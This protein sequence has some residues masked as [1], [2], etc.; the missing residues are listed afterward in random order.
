MYLTIAVTACT[1]GTYG[2]NCSGVC[3]CSDNAT[4]DHITGQCPSTC[5]DGWN[6]IDCSI[7][8]E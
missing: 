2:V 4:C 3:H 7:P 6:G 1:A 8:G 5:D